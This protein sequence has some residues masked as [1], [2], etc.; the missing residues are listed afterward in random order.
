MLTLD[1]HKIWLQEV[2]FVGLLDEPNVILVYIPVA[3]RYFRSYK[4]SVFRA[5]A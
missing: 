2:Y 4:I 3:K 1:N 5:D